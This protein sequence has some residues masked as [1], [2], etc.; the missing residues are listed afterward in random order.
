LISLPSSEAFRDSRIQPLSSREGGS[1]NSPFSRGRR[2]RV[3]FVFFFGESDR[4]SKHCLFSFFPSRSRAKT[5]TMT[6]G[7]GRGPRSSALCAPLAIL[8]CL[9][10]LHPLIQVASAAPTAAAAALPRGVRPS[11]ARLYPSALESSSATFRCLDGSGEPLPASRVNDDYCDCVDG[12]DEPG[13]EVERSGSG[14]GEKERERERER[15]REHR[16]RGKGLSDGDRSVTIAPFALRPLP[17]PF[18][19][20]LSLPTPP[21]PFPQ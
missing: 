12:S 6:R 13:E 2:K 1:V 18:P 11:R 9:L 15:E 3:C 21:P 19:S 14:E 5:K 10:M 17:R 4:G 8:S 7:R 16:R 20:A